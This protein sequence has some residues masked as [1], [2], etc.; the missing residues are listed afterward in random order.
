MAGGVLPPAHESF[1]FFQGAHPAS[2]Y[3]L[4]H[5]TRIRTTQLRDDRSIIPAT[6][7]P[8]QSRASNES[9]TSSSQNG[10]TPRRKNFSTVSPG[11]Q[12]N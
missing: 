4:A 6:I 8:G 3:T 12:T 5:S 11:G 2:G 10:P 1:A 9:L 7:L